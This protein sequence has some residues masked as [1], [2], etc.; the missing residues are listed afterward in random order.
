MTMEND[1]IPM[2]GDGRS[3]TSST[4]ATGSNV[5]IPNHPIYLRTTLTA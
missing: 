2:T 5:T 4:I 1:V 3:S